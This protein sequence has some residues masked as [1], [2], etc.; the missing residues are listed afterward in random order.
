VE[1]LIDTASGTEATSSERIAASTALTLFEQLDGNEALH[2]GAARW[3]AT[4][5]SMPIADRVAAD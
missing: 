2:F 4:E 3:L 5:L 1:L